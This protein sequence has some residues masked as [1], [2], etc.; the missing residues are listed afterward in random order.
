MVADG[1]E[2]FATENIWFY[3]HPYPKGY[4]SYSKT[5][6]IRIEEFEPE[7]AWWGKEE[8]DFS[9]REENE[10]A[11][12]VDFKTKR[13]EAIN[14]AQPHWNKA[15]ELINQASELDN[16]AKALRESLRGTKD[17]AN[18]EQVNSQI[19]EL[20]TKIESLR[21]KSGDAKATGDRLYWPIYNLDITNPNAP[22]E[23]SHD[24]DILLEKYKQLLG[25]IEET[26]NTLKSE[27]AI[28][29]AHHFDNEEA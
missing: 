24:P 6:P 25:E 28:A 1:N 19:L 15:D 27:L 21:L 26:E 11:W 7:K 9:E 3:E 16:Q 22:E 13:A 2:Q 10:F 8:N 18:R 4:K 12:K 17:T 23:E 29:L 5:K 20:Q 14:A